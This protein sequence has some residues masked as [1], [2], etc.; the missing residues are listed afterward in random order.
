MSAWS[1]TDDHRTNASESRAIVA[2]KCSKKNDQ[3]AHAQ[4]Y[5]DRDTGEECSGILEVAW[6]G[7]VLRRAT[8]RV[9][10]RTVNCWS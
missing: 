10:G 2:S 7:T 6:H 5:Q 9:D 3:I 8:C 1:G 4:C